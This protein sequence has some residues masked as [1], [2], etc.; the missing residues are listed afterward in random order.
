MPKTVIQELF[1]VIYDDY[2]IMMNRARGSFSS[3]FLT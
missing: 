3:S 1:P 2:G